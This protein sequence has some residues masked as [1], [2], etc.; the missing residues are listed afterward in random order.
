MGQ[1]APIYTSPMTA[2]I[3]GNTMF[4]FG[5]HTG[6]GTSGYR[7]NPIESPTSTHTS[8][9]QP[10]FIDRPAAVYSFKDQSLQNPQTLQ[11]A[12]SSPDCSTSLCVNRLTVQDNTFQDIVDIQRKQAEMSQIMVSQQA[13][14]L[15][16]SSNSPM[17]Y[18]DAI[19]F[20]AFLTAFESLIESMVEDSC[21]RLY[22]LRQY[23][24]A[25]LKK[26]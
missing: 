8:L 14:S 7:A 21:E 18:G 16:L 22:F 12:Y 9:P 24:S 15:L 13:R 26:L 25:K 6:T 19:E 1:P 4:D 10:H 11:H 20:P 5:I 23:T 2:L 3:S 17:F